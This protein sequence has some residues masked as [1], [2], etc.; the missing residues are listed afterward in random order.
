VRV[1]L[2]QLSS[3]DEP[4]ANLAKTLAKIEEA[5]ASGARFV[6]TPE[7]TNCVSASRTHQKAVLQVESEDETLAALRLAARQL[8]IWLLIGSLALSVEDDDRFVNRSF[9]I[10]PNGEISARYDKI[11]MFDVK[12]SDEET[13]KESA[14]YRAGNTAVVAQVDGVKVGL[15][16]CYDLRFP[17]L[18]RDLCRAGAEVIAVPSAFAVKTGVAHWEPLMRARAIENGAFVLAP[19]QCGTHVATRGRERKTYGHSMVVD[20]WG[21]VLAVADDGPDVLRV[22]LDL[23]AVESARQRIPSLIHHRDYTLEP[24]TV[25]KNRETRLQLPCSANFSWL[26]NWLVRV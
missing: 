11:H 26:I 3:S 13:Y 14:G 10:D 25:R 18:F 8:D 21:Q 9:L 15:T 12:I 6:L 19:A 24:W 20:P 22:D 7:V 23:N 1:A 16:I 17:Q 2:V 5:A 4:R